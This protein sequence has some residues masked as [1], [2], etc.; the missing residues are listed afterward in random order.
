MFVFIIFRGFLEIL[1]FFFKQD[2]KKEENSI[3]LRL[4]KNK[5]LP[6]FFRKTPVIKSVK[7]DLWFTEVS[8]ICF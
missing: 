3:P 8:I 4:V 7:L 6:Y 2:F 5:S 1:F